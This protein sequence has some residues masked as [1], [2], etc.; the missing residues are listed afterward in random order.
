[1]FFPQGQHLMLQATTASPPSP[2]RS[3]VGMMS[4]DI[5]TT[6]VSFSVTT[7]AVVLGV[8]ASVVVRGGFSHTTQS[9]TPCG[10]ENSPQ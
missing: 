6:Q 7:T 1:M 9:R 5:S 10:H 2:P 4:S 3:T 8:V